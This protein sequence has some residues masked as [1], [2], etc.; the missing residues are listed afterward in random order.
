[1]DFMNQALQ[2]GHA[3]QDI[4]ANMLNQ[5]KFQKSGFDS[6]MLMETVKS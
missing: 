3:P 1:M 2:Q 4:L 5:T 6:K